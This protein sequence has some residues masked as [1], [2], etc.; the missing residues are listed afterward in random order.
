MTRSSQG[1]EPPSDPGRFTDTFE[2]KP[3]TDAGEATITLD[4]TTI[5]ELRAHKARQNTERLTAGAAWTETGFVFTTPTGGP[6]DPNEVT[7]QFEQL[8]MEAGLPPVRLH[9][10]RHGAATFLLAAGYDLKVVQETL[11]LSSLA[12]AADIYTS[13]LPQ[14]A[15]QSA[16]DAAAVVLGTHRTNRKRSRAKVTEIP[17][18]PAPARG[19][20]A[21]GGEA[22]GPA[23]AADAS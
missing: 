11:R 17:A 8:S 9:D 1:N 10:L 2:G 18:P 15:R 22:T 16:E 19:A 3:K 6:V 4:K 21:D 7:E 13:V 23:T 14:L 12:I 5:K 20:A